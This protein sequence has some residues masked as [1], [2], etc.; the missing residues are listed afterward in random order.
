MEDTDGAAQTTRIYFSEFRVG[1]RRSSVLLS[2][3]SQ[4]ETQLKNK[5]DHPPS[6]QQVWTLKP[7]PLMALYLALSNAE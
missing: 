6:E 2:S 1:G 3:L 7:D 5:Q 4:K